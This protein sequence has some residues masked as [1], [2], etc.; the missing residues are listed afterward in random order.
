MLKSK[1]FARNLIT[2]ATFAGAWL[3][4]SVCAQT[5]SAIAVPA[6]PW[7]QLTTS[8][9][10][11]AAPADA[12]VVEATLKTKSELLDM[13]SV[14]Y[15]DA[16]Y[17]AEFTVDRMLSGAYAEKELTVVLWNFRNREVQPGARLVPG[18]KLRLTL[19]P[20]LNK[21][22]LTKTNLSDDLQRFD[23]PL[24]YAEKFEEIKN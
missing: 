10:I 17:V 15:P 19:T 12:I 3:G 1:A 2:L 23:L 14:N 4:S 18:Q 21:G 13:A 24:L 5:A 22:D 6:K 9:L 7:S 20:W 16:V 8:E 11:T